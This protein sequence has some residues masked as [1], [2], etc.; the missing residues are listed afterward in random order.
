LYA[1][2]AQVNPWF[3]PDLEKAT[4]WFTKAHFS[5]PQDHPGRIQS[6]RRRDDPAQKKP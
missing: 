1:G 4:A 5:F 6:D 2:D 3:K